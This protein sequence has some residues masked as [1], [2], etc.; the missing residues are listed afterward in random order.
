[1]GNDNVR[2]IKSKLDIVE[3]VG[4]YVS[5]KKKGKSY[6]GCCPFH[7]EKT[8]SFT[9][10]RERQTFHCFGCN[11]GGDIF[12][13]LMEIEN[14]DFVEA[15][16]RLAERTG[17]K[18]ERYNPS[19]HRASKTL[20]DINIQAQEFF[21]K[22]LAGVSGKVA[23]AYLDRRRI[24]KEEAARFGL[25]WAPDSWNSLYDNLVSQGYS[26][27]EMIDS[28]LVSQ[29]EHGVYDRFR[30]RVMF[31]IYD[32]TDRLI[33][34]GGRILAGD[35][36]KYLNS[37]ESQLFNKRNNLYLLNKAKHS[38]RKEGSAILVEGYM[39]AIRAHLK[40][41]TNTVASLGT[42]LTETQAMLIKR[43]AGLC[44]ICYDADSAGAQATLR[45]MYI[46][47]KVGVVVK[48]MRLAT[49]KDPDEVLLR[50][51]GVAEFKEAMDNAL[52]LPVYHAMVNSRDFDIPEK[53]VEAKRELLDGLASLSMFDVLP[54]INDIS[55]I[56]GLFPH[57][58][59]KELNRR[60]GNIRGTSPV[61]RMPEDDYI[62]RQDEFPDDFPDD[63]ECL[64]CSLLW[65]NENLRS[66]FTPLQT[67]SYFE[68]DM[69]KMIVTG[70]L[71][72]E[73]PEALEDRWRQMEESNLISVIAKGNSL[74]ERGGFKENAPYKILEAL[75]K[76]SVEKRVAV[77]QER[78]KKG[79]ATDSDL[80]EHLELTK[81]LKGGALQSEEKN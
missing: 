11:R 65:A 43:M 77:L 10:S 31:P 32:V 33:G 54:Y 14:I 79:T 24:N 73:T 20:R 61:R 58:L 29:G 21:E 3:L 2:E 28:G 50:E 6:W 17:V 13:F 47:Q 70:L 57:E 40:G 19:K 25:G 34:Y 66:Q 68:S 51:N 74:M 26:D 16:E 15:L 55:R 35:S 45:G 59:R 42:A 56:L 38:M 39:D 53:A 41:F 36:A 7:G 63:P 78:L 12:S 69:A 64:F 72:G 71:N 75:Q 1:M 44:Y 48:V 62:D 49:G 18:L 27:K 30:G 76:R 9:V 46:L 37:P 23:R 81:I 5:L 80:K 8:P 4:D 67:V 52:A 60:H 22:A